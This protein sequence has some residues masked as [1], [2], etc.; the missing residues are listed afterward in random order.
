MKQYDNPKYFLAVTLPHGSVVCTLFIPLHQ[1][2]CL[3]SILYWSCPFLYTAGRQDHLALPN[4]QIYQALLLS[5]TIGAVASKLF[6]EWFLPITCHNPGL[7]LTVKLLMSFQTMLLLNKDKINCRCLYI[8]LFV[9]HNHSVW[10]C[11]CAS[12]ISFSD[13]VTNFISRTWKFNSEHKVNKVNNL[14]V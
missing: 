4:K 12:D 3:L 8:F 2:V 6:K 1:F 9:L 5:L 13:W 14:G 10:M 7:V 11:S